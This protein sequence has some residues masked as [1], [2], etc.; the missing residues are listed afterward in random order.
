V[1][2]GVELR[3]SHLLGRSSTTGTTL[4]ALFALLIFEIESCPDRP[5]V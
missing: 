5:R 4:T 3:M 1:V 2:S